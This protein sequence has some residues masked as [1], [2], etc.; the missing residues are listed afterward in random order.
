M[1]S[2]DAIRYNYST[3]RKSDF[4]DEEEKLSEW[5]LA[6]YGLI[7]SLIVITGK[8]FHGNRDELYSLVFEKQLFKHGTLT[9]E[10]E[11]MMRHT[12][13]TVAKYSQI[14]FPAIC[15]LATTWFTWL[16]V[17]L[18]SRVPGVQPPSPLSPSKYKLQSGHT[19][20]LNYLFA[21]IVGIF[22]FTYMY[23]KEIYIQF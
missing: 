3:P 6:L 21:V 1:T 22:V 16:I 14:W 9:T 12:W 7:L 10:G 8:L 2:Y 23:V 15:G 11:L 18:D 13:K 19:F 17:Y 5:K 20:H 4:K